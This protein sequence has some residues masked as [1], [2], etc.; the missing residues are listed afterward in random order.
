MFQFTS[1]GG[2]I[3]DEI[4]RR[5]CPYVL[6]ICGQNYHKIGLLLPL[7]GQPPKF[8]QLYIYDTEHEVPN[9]MKP[10]NSLKNKSGIN[11]NVVDELVKMFDKTNVIVQAFRIARD[12]CAQSGFLQVR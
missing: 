5:P 1:I 4:N 3:D 10:F 8:A 6:R 11:E 12:K 9:R 2:R 7:D